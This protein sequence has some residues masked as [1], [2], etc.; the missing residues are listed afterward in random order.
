MIRKQPRDMHT[1]RLE[2]FD[3]SWR[4]EVLPSG[5]TL[6]SVPRPHDDHFF[7]GVTLKVG[8]RLEHG[9]HKPGVSHFLEHMM[10][11]GSERYPDYA[12]LAEAFEWLGGDW[13]AATGHEHTEYWYSGIK[14]TAAEVI[15]LFANFIASPQFTDIEVER[16][17][18]TRELDGETNDHGHCTDLDYHIA[19]LLWPGTTLAQPILGSR[20]SIASMS[21]EDLRRYRDAFYVPHNMAISVVGGDEHLLPLLRSAF[22]DLRSSLSHVA[23]VSFPPLKRQAGPLVKWVEHSDN[24]YE[25]KLS[26]VCGSEWS[27]EAQ[28]SE[29]VSRILADGFCSRLGRRL[30]EQLG[31]VYDI[32]AHPTLGLEV[33]TLDIGASCAQDQLD[34]FMTELLR[35][36]KRLA[37]DGPTPEELERARVRSIVDLEL[38]PTVP[39]VIGTRLPWA[40]LAGRDLSL[41]AER[42]RIKAVTTEAAAAWCRDTL[43]ASNAALAVLGPAAKDIEKRLKKALIAGL[44]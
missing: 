35:E 18:I 6:F 5:L 34:E 9:K 30:R 25:I 43:K 1:S 28:T 33:G 44:G 12:Q 26:F 32:H 40:Y 2:Q 23:K 7:L 13:N 27:T 14:H 29:L 38:A 3:G 39:E 22:G 31:L 20:E 36:L 8:T 19:N 41:V 4:R 37:A 21:V 24:E 10:F 15:D 42:E 17:I 11:R 16:S